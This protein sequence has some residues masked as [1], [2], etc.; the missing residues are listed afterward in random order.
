MIE[1]HS[2]DQQ[3]RRQGAS[4]REARKR[5]R[6]LVEEFDLADKLCETVYDLSIGTK[7]RVQ[8]AKIF[9]LDSPVIFLDEATTAW[10]R[11][12]APGYGAYKKLTR[13]IS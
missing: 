9:M 5:M 3:S 11:S 1:V 12:K 13:T 8:V 6:T 7:R 4:R 2:G 10:T